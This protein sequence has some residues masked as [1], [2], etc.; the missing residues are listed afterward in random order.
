MSFFAEVF[1]AQAVR[2]IYGSEAS[3]HLTFDDGPDAAATPMVLDALRELQCQAT[4]F[5]V[6]EKAKIYPALVRRILEEGHAVGNHSADHRY[7]S[8]FRGRTAMLEWIDSSLD[9]F[10]ALGVSDLVGFRPPA[11]VVTPELIWAL[12]TRQIP[13]VLWNTRFYDTVFA[14]SERTARRSAEMVKPGAIVL[15]HD[16]EGSGWQ[17]DGAP[18]LRKFVEVARRR[19]LRFQTLTRQ[20]CA[21]KI[22]RSVF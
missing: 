21:A 2:R 11:G 22:R 5:L 16:S 18:A 10:R 1:G 7:R 13:L 6:A 19:G 3:I 4:F 14:W 12:Q 17:K 9:T 20:L 8:F 15:L